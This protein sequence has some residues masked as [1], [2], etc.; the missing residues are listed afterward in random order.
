[1]LCYHLGTKGNIYTNTTPY[2][3]QDVTHTIFKLILVLHPSKPLANQFQYILK[4]LSSK[5]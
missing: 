3:F 5:K 1:M 2:K 4:S